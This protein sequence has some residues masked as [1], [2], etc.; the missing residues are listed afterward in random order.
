VC[1]TLG[2]GAAATGTA[3]A[4]LPELSWHR[5]PG[6]HQRNFQCAMARG[7]PLDYDLPAGATIK[8]AVIRR[9]ATDPSRRIGTLFFNPGG[10]GGPGTQALPMWYQRFPAA[11]R[12]RFNIV[13]W[14]P[15]GVGQSTAV[16]CFA[17]RAA[18]K[19]FFSHVPD[20]FPVGRA[21]RRA[22]IRGY[23]RFGRRCLQRNGSL[24]EHVSTRESAED[25]NLLRRAVGERRL[26]YLGVSYGTLLGA[27]YANLFPHS[28]RAMVLDGNVDPVAWAKR[29]RL[30]TTMRQGSD[31]A[32]AGALRGFLK[33]CGLAS[34]SACAFSAGSPRLTRD[35]WGALLRRVRRNP[36][37]RPQHLTY[38]DLATQ[39]VN[40]LYAPQPGPG[41]QGWPASAQLLQQ[42]WG[43][44][45]AR[46]GDALARASA[47][48]RGRRY[49]G[50][51]QALAVQC[52]DSPNPRTA[53]AFRRIATAAFRRAREIGR[54]WA[55]GDEPCASWPAMAVD[56]YAGPWNR[57]T[58]SPVLVIGNTSDPATPYQ[59]ALAMSRYLARARLLTV[60]GYGHTALLNPSACANAYESAYLVRGSLPPPETVC[61]QD[62]LPFAGG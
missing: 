5:C 14:D 28:I 46:Q 42:L 10:P 11:V 9:R 20:G 58:S 27:T 21:Q 59:N 52:S 3:E 23:A 7:V 6:A 48:G 31:K 18:E 61:R 30:S 37:S 35:K 29:G 41:V 44:T 2:V 50:P 39:M 49:S 17:R 43:A 47:S 4:V 22:W 32:S 55:W 56:R 62:R 24:L 1:A 57:R 19:K 26:N 13:S 16:Q 15:R 34:T 54:A 25:L 60:E 33:L 12:A 45:G 8:L 40:V 38:A 53:A 51:E 36:L